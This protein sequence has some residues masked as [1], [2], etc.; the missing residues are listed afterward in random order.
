MPLITAHSAR[1]VPLAQ[2]AAEAIQILPVSL[3]VMFVRRGGALRIPSG[4]SLP[5]LKPCAESGAQPSPLT[6]TQ[7]LSLHHL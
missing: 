7:K 4:Q 6:R 1:Y 3:H 2:L 5:R